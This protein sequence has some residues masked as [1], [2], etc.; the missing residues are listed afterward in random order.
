MFQRYYEIMEK[1]K[2]KF[3]CSE[4]ELNRIG[5][6]LL[7]G[8]GKVVVAKKLFKLNLEHFP[9]SIQSFMGMAEVAIKE[10]HIPEAKKYFKKAL[11]HLLKDTKLD[12]DMK[13]IFMNRVKYKMKN[14]Q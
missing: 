10:N 5:N 7:N 8:L 2:E 11:N 9:E 3:D 13:E 1:E 14:I 12:K 4:N 6:Y